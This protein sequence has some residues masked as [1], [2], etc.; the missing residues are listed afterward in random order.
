MATK[1]LHACSLLLALVGLTGCMSYMSDPAGSNI[2]LG[3]TL[4]GASEVPPNASTA[5]GYLTALYSTSTK[6]FKWRLVVN[7]LSSP[8]TRAEFHGPDALGNDAA[9][10]PVNPPFNGTTHLGGATLTPQQ[11]TDLLAGRWYLDIRTEKFPAG[12]I[13][14][15]VVRSK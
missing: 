11:A 13:R 15:R 10:V 3:G 12:E 4:N 9:L 8:I 5:G 14:G 6:I 7:G 1:M 2:D